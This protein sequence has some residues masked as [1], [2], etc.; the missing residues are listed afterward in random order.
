MKLPFADL[1]DWLGPEAQNLWATS[2]TVDEEIAFAIAYRS[3]GSRLGGST[4]PPVYL[5][6]PY[7][8]YR[9]LGP[10]SIPRAWLHPISVPV[11]TPLPT[12]HPKLMLASAGD[13]HRV[14]VSTGNLAMDDVSRSR[15]LVARL[16]VDWATANAVKQWITQW[17]QPRRALCFYARPGDV[18]VLAAQAGASSY[19]QFKSLQRPCAACAKSRAPQGEWILAAPFWSPGALKALL[20]DTPGAAVR[21]YFRNQALWNAVGATATQGKAAV[22]TTSV[23]AYELGN[24]ERPL[25]WH[26]KVF[27][28]R[29]CGRRSG[30]AVL[31]VGSANATVSGF[32]GKGGQAVNWE[33]GVIWTGASKLWEVAGLAAAGGLRPRRLPPHEGKFAAVR[34]N[35]EL[36][37][38]PSEELERLL[39]ACAGSWIRVNRSKRTVTRSRATGELRFLGAEW[40]LKSYRLQLD[41]RDELKDVGELRYGQPRIVPAGARPIVRAVF[42]CVGKP[43]LGLQKRAPGLAQLCELDPE[44]PLP[45]VDQGGSISAARAGLSIGWA[46]S[47]TGQGQGSRSAGAAKKWEDVRFPFSEF[48]D[49]R[50]RNKAAAEAWLERVLSKDDPMLQ[51]LPEHWLRI[52]S[53][54]RRG[55]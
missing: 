55:P 7:A 34:D 1:V 35:D 52:A 40:R 31:Y 13:E 54:L 33:A 3:I 11:E 14:V 6:F 23:V 17:P 36:G 46:G 27:A 2:F 51:R 18:G 43:P 5:R 16:E 4:A 19:A 26:H 37:D 10:G 9:R 28:W 49:G 22:S 48:F 8:G 53:A 42:E 25:P 47:S 41:E 45:D 30:R 44:P 20:R 24:S 32:F 29:C 12:Y 21:A 15:N 38:V 39:G 50:R